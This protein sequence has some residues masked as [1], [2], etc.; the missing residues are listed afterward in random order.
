MNKKKKNNNQGTPKLKVAPPKV[1]GRTKRKLEK[2][3]RN[4]SFSFSSWTLIIVQQR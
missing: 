2:K 3:S 1:E 4:L